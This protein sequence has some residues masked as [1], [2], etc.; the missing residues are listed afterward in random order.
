MVNRVKSALAKTKSETAGLPKGVKKIAQAPMDFAKVRWLIGQLG[1]KE[2]CALPRGLQKKYLRFLD[3]LHYN[4]KHH[5]REVYTY[6]NILCHAG[7]P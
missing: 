7:R 6:K 3:P 1:A 4:A 2:F 5:Q